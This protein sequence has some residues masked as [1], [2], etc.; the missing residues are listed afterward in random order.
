VAA[1]RIHPNNLPELGPN[2]VGDEPIELGYGELHRSATM[3]E[4]ALYR[5][6]ANLGV[7]RSAANAGIPVLTI[8]PG[9]TVELVSDAELGVGYANGG[10][11]KAEGTPE[12]PIKFTGF[13]KSKGSWNGIKLYSEAKDVSIKNAVVEYAKSSDTEGAV[14]A[15]SN[16]VGTLENVTFAHLEGVGLSRDYESKVTGKDLKADDAK[17]AE[18]TPGQ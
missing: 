1:M 7:Q 10:T 3:R 14:R 2:E 17:A 8:E 6:M 13:D 15:Y 9:V 11:L 4:G 16:A 18:L 12:K 5:I